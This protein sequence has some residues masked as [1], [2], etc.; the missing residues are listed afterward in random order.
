[1]LRPNR[2]AAFFGAGSVA[3]PFDA[4]VI[5]AVRKPGAQCVRVRVLGERSGA[6]C[7]RRQRRENLIFNQVTDGAGGGVRIAVRDRICVVVFAGIGFGLAQRLFKCRR[8]ALVFGVN[9]NVV[10]PVHT[11]DARHG[12]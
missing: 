9:G 3:E 10:V 11:V 2:H 4:N 6:G 12:Q 8:G 1:M 7:D 5:F